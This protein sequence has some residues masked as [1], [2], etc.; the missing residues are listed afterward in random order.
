MKHIT[1]FTLIGLLCSMAI[2]QIQFIDKQGKAFQVRDGQSA[3][4]VITGEAAQLMS[5]RLKLTSDSQVQCGSNFCVIGQFNRDGVLA[6]LTGEL[7]LEKLAK[8]A[9]A[10]LN[11]TYLF[12][13]LYYERYASKA[14]ALP[15]QCQ[16]KTTK[17]LSG[18]T[19]VDIEGVTAEMLYNFFGADTAKRK[20][21]NPFNCL[22]K[23]QY[24]QA[25]QGS[26]GQISD[27]TPI[28]YIEYSCEIKISPEGKLQRP[29]DCH[30]YG[31]SISAGG[32]G[33]GG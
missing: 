32:G 23:N 13:E 1:L 25:D 10:Q 6:P 14:S 33:G 11:P 7:S 15:D 8:R 24:D 9:Q 17:E 19:E 28:S 29:K 12:D 16:E 22:K 26:G 20:N 5:S 2:G 4:I 18:M 21:P 3:A 30:I 31:G 27:H